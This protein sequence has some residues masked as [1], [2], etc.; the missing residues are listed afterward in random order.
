MHN[1]LSDIEASKFLGL[2]PQTL[3]NWRFQ[4]KGPAYSRVG[5]RIIYILE[6]LENYRVKNRVDPENF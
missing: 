2:K 1:A 6:D 5:R 4:M 3:R